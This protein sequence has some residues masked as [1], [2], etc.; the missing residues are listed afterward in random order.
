MSVLGGA[1]VFVLGIIGAPVGKSRLW[2]S[3]FTGRG[4]LTEEKKS[5]SLM[6]YV[7]KVIFESSISMD[8]YSIN[9][10]YTINIAS[11]NKLVHVLWILI[12]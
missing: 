4:C 3:S 7:M 5:H 1:D 6:L 9:Y 10:H 8:L 2:Y 12:S 11:F